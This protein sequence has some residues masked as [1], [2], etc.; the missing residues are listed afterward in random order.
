MTAAATKPHYKLASGAAANDKPVMLAQQPVATAA[1]QVVNADSVMHAALAC[2]ADPARMVQ[3]LEIAERMRVAEHKRVYDEAML[4]FRRL[5]LRAR[6]TAHV[7]Q[8][9][10]DGK[11]GKDYWHAKLCETIDV[12]EQPL[13][14]VGITFS[15]DVDESARDWVRVSCVIRHVAGYS[16]RVTLGAPIDLSGGKTGPQGI[17]SSVSYLKRYT[18]EL[19]LGMA[20]VDEDDDGASAGG[21]MPTIDR[22]SRES[23]P[24]AAGSPAAA[25]IAEG[26]ARADQG[27]KALTA[28]W[29]GLAQSQRESIM[30]QFAGLKK[31]ALA[32][33]D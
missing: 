3:L 17:G 29:G 13:T 11:A 1:L 6:K 4:L 33:G 30:P 21:S 20:E 26:E 23:N 19:A 22:S 12:V 25:L 15:W 24:P 7:Q 9:A 5:G 27:L 8:A 28:W 31:Q 16:E 2:V 18:L 14:S 10:K 32:A